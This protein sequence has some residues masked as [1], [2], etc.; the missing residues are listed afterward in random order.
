MNTKRLVAHRG[1]NTNY[2][3]NSYAGIEAALLAGALFVEFDIQMNADGSLIVFHDTDFK[4]TANLDTS[5]FDTSDSVLK[6]ISVHEPKRFGEQHYPTHIP[7]LTEILSLLMQHPEA[8]AFVE[9]K[10]ESLNHWGLQKVMDK[11][12]STLENQTSQVTIISFS[13]AA[14]TYT[15]QHSKIRTGLVFRKY[16]K[17]T[18]LLAQT[19]KPD[20]LICSRF[21]IPNDNLWSGNWEWM[22]Y[23]INEVP[24][25]KTMLARKE[26]KLIETDNIRLMINA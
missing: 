11:L 17:H 3:E 2:P 20:Y 14:L 25:M 18:H 5:V 15:Q 1:D 7:H 24:P 8:Q 26:I 16:N 12:L 22:V 9:M 6:T 23:S 10:I 13:D 19:L 4:R 21:I